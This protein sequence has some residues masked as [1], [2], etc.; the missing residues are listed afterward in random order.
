PGLLRLN[1]EF[2]AGDRDGAI[3][4]LRILIA[5]TGGRPHLPEEGAA[6]DLVG[7]AG[8]DTPLR[9]NLARTVIDMRRD[10]IW[11][12]RERRGLPPLQPASYGLIWDGRYRIA[13]RTA[14]WDVSSQ[15]A[16]AGDPSQGLPP[17]VWRGAAAAEPRFVASGREADPA[18]KPE[19][20]PVAAPW[21][22]FLPSFD[23]QPARSVMRLIGAA[24]PPDLP[25]SGKTSL[26]P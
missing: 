4:A 24:M 13:A 25:E 11:L 20:V 3:Y 15:A 18:N 6:A 7:A 21:A 10:A 26:D 14:G 12:H 8:A 22:A 1:R 2:C 23:L 17:I 19:T 9:T 5:V 16:V